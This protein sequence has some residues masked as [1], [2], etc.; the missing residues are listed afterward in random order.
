MGGM[1]SGDWYRFDKKSTVEESLTLGNAGF[2]RGNLPAFIGHFGLDLGRR[3][4]VFGQLSRHL[5]RLPDYHAALLL[6]G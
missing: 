2:S 5:G 4:H 3:Q 6:A 1:G